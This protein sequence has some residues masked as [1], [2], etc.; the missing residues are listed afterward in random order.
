MKNPQYEKNLQKIA[1]QYEG[2]QKQVRQIITNENLRLRFIDKL[3][4]QYKTL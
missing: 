1:H 2:K 4:V 3:H